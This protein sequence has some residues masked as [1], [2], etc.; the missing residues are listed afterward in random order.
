M[1]VTTARLTNDDPYIEGTFTTTLQPNNL[2]KV[3]FSIGALP[4][5]QAKQGFFGYTISIGVNGRDSVQLKP[6]SPS[7]W[8]SGAYTHT[9]TDVPYGTTMWFVT[10]APMGNKQISIAYDPPI[11]DPPTPSNLSLSN[12]SV[13]D[14]LQITFDWSIAGDCT[15]KEFQIDSNG[16][17]SASAN[18]FT[19]V[20]ANTYRT[21]AL[22]V[23]T[24]TIQMR[25]N[26]CNTSGCSS[27]SNSNTLTVE[28]DY[29]DFIY[30]IR[31]NSSAKRCPAYLLKNGKKIR[32]TKGNTK[33]LKR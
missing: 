14:D 30:I 12:A 29:A 16:F 27:W 20:D 31:P 25:A 18:G 23:G 21:P 3:D 33:V 19:T 28:V 26:N 2:Y 1:A 6:A 7:T 17:K 11:P 32:L 9:F 8:G 4:N 10:N 22:S 13:N 15:N 5:P 24:H